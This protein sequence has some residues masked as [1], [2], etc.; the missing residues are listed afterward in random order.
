MLHDFLPSRPS[1]KQSSV[2]LSLYHYLYLYLN[3]CLVLWCFHRSFSVYSFFLT[4]RH[5]HIAGALIKVSLDP[6]FPWHVGGF[7]YIHKL[8]TSSWKRLP[9]EKDHEQKEMKVRWCKVRRIRRMSKDL[10][11]TGQ[12]YHL[13]SVR[14]KLG[15]C[16][17][18]RGGY[19]WSTFRTC[20][21]C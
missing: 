2:Y 19:F 20:W 8:V 1:S 7:L 4:H 21:F 11:A 16:R 9:S 18:C 17:S 14:Y 5:T 10:V 15:P 6:L 13:D 12:C 3:T